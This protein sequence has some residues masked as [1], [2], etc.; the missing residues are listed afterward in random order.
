LAADD[1]PS[2]FLIEGAD[3]DYTIS[4]TTLTLSSDAADLVET[5]DKLS[6]SYQIASA[7]AGDP[8]QPKDTIS[9]AAIRGYP[10]VP[11][12]IRVL[13]ES[14]P[15]RGMQSIEATMNFN[16]NVE[17]GMGSQAIGSERVIPAEVT[18]NFT[19]FQEDYRTEMMLMT[20][21]T[22]P[23][24]T[25]FPIEAYRD[26]IVLELDFKHPDTGTILRTDTLSG[27]TVTGDGRD[28]AVGSAVGKNFNF[29]AATNFTWYN[30][31]HV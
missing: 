18:G 21:E 1:E 13:S 12:T 23:S 26:D 11:V 4:G 7:P 14:Y 22:S 5:G 24:D 2:T 6:V 15:V 20:G 9:P 25:D 10:N 27:I 3:N 17:V 30:T 19:V 29:S 16:S 31:K 28:V 8:F